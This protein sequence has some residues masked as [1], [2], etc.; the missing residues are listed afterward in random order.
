MNV[1]QRLR[2]NSDT[3]RVVREPKLKFDN[4]TYSRFCQGLAT[5][6]VVLSSTDKRA[7]YDR[8]IDNRIAKHLGVGPEGRLDPQVSQARVV[9]PPSTFA[10]DLDS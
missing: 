8:I 9:M 1:P 10:W 3:R 5:R 4:N 7:L 2:L 6:G